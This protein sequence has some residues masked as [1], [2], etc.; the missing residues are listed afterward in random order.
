MCG[1]S[2]IGL[3]TG[4]SIRD[5]RPLGDVHREVAHALQVGIDLQR[6]DDQAQVGRHGLLQGEQVDGELVD[7]DLDRVDARFVAKYFFGGAA[8]LLNHGA[9]AALDGRFDQRAHLQQL[10]LQLF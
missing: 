3:M 7:L 1:I 6:G 5:S 10:G 2:I 9:D 4:S 8:V